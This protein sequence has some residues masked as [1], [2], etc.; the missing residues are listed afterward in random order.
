MQGLWYDL[1]D[2]WYMRPLVWAICIGVLAA[3]GIIAEVNYQQV[4]APYNITVCNKERVTTSTGGGEYRLYAA[5]GTFVMADSLL[6]VTRYNTADQY[7]R[8]KAK[9]TYTVTTKGWRIPFFSAFPNVLTAEPA[10]ADQQ[11]PSRCNGFG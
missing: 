3:L 2:P 4:S 10:P 8:I 1:R 7:A 11:Q 5:E 9:T 6:G